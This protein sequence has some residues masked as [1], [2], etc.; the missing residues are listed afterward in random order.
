M[1]QHAIAPC[2]APSSAIVALL[3]RGLPPL[4]AVLLAVPMAKRRGQRQAEQLR[5]RRRGGP[6]LS[7][8]NYRQQNGVV[9]FSDKGPG[10]AV[11][12]RDGILLLRLQPRCDGE[13]GAPR[14]CSRQE[15]ATPIDVAAKGARVDPALVRAVIHAGPR[16]TLP[17][18]AQGAIGLK[19]SRIGH[20]S[21]HWPS[22]VPTQCQQQH[23]GGVKYLAM[24]LAQVH[25]QR[26]A[27]TVAY[28]AGPGPCRV[29]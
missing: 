28:N 6:A 5:Q 29:Y 25:R 12:Q 22:S 2:T 16:S 18:R 7:R 20:A 3:R 27:A 17:R 14:G 4:L 10:A 13:L 21:E 26:H 11:L 15:F 24:L 9:A 23:P 8:L 1:R 19:C